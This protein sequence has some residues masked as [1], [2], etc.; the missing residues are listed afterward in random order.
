MTYKY[1]V[2]EDNMN[3]FESFRKSGNYQKELAKK[4][5]PLFEE[6]LKPSVNKEP[7]RVLEIGPGSGELTIDLFNRIALTRRVTLDILESDRTMVNVLTELLK[8][9]SLKFDVDKIFERK[10][11]DFEVDATDGKYDLILAAHSFYGILEEN[12]D[13]IVREKLFYKMLRALSYNG[14]LCIIMAGE[15]GEDY[16]F[17]LKFNQQ[18]NNEL[19]RNWNLATSKD[20][21]NILHDLGIFP[22]KEQMTTYITYMNMTPCIYNDKELENKDGKNWLSYSFRID[23]NELSSHIKSM[24]NDYLKEKTRS[25]DSVSD[26]IKKQDSPDSIVDPSSRIFTHYN[27]IFFI[28]KPFFMVIVD[29]SFDNCNTIY[30]IFSDYC[31]SN[32]LIMK[33]IQKKNDI[34]S[35]LSENIPNL[36]LLDKNIHHENDGIKWIEDNINLLK[37]QNIY[38]AIITGGGVRTHK[39]R[40]CK[41]HLSYH[42]FLGIYSRG[43]ESKIKENLARILEAPGIEFEELEIIDE[44][45]DSVLSQLHIKRHNVI[46][47]LNALSLSLQMVMKKRGNQDRWKKDLIHDAELVKN[48][49]P[50]M[51]NSLK[52][53]FAIISQDKDLEKHIL[54]KPI[55][56]GSKDADEIKDIQDFLLRQLTGIEGKLQS[57]LEYSQIIYEFIRNLDACLSD[58][59]STA[60][61]YDQ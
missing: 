4:L 17:K 26:D 12:L 5:P 6:H 54:S 8:K 3:I 18:I 34:N 40:C 9:N 43:K 50:T 47:P 51:K 2:F 31:T 22:P 55:K 58:L 20:V 11:E 38:T 46:N 23:Y 48:S 13:K 49:I 10:W 29:T 41:I 32:R 16:V 27:D 45:E 7:L 39:N 37:E 15:E 36:I 61:S 42:K 56:I 35:Y 24:I 21:K 30:D 14:L 44:D 52:G 1:R 28:R 33:Y 59:I 60:D 57:V 53:M 19:D 25:F